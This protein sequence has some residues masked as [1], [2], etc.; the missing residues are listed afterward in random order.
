MTIINK[1]SVPFKATRGVLSIAGAIGASALAGVAIS[2]FTPVD[3][4][5]Y[6]KVAIKVASVAIVWAA[7]DAG[8][9]IVQGQLDQLADQVNEIGDAFSNA[10]EK[11]NIETD[12]GEV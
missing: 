3:V 4:K 1:E 11:I 7:S 9:K 12:R 5:L 2:Y 6:K 10:K 8:A